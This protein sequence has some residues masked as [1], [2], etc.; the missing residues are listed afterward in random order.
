MWGVGVFCY[1]LVGGFKIVR[2]VDYSRDDGFLEALEEVMVL[3]GLGL[4]AML[5][6]TLRGGHGCFY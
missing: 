1:D 5:G 2:Q 4:A 6:L 3:L